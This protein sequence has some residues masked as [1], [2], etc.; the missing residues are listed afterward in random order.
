MS[1]EGTSNPLDI[2]LYRKT[3]LNTPWAYI[4]TND[5]SDESILRDGGLIFG[6]KSTAICNLLNLLLFFFLSDFV[7]SNGC[8]C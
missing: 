8:K 7:I 1:K 5:K 2:Y 3:P 6:R 4:R